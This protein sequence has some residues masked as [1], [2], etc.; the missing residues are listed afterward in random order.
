ML[1]DPRAPHRWVYN[2]LSAPLCPV[3]T[4]KQDKRL[5]YNYPRNLPG[6][7]IR[8]LP[9]TQ[10]VLRTWPTSV[11]VTGADLS[12]QCHNGLIIIAKHIESIDKTSLHS[13]HTKLQRTS[14]GFY[15]SPSGNTNIIV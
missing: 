13:A 8:L 9:W 1:E 3:E 10:N 15:G 6:Q 11:T 14:L 4:R 7:S 5:A 12:F 2:R